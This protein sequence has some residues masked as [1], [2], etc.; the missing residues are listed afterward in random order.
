MK[1]RNENTTFIQ[2]SYRSFTIFRTF[3]KTFIVKDLQ[4]KKAP[5]KGPFNA[6][7]KTL[8]EGS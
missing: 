2:F 4:I 1:N 7:F 5:F 8:A 6:I 3:F